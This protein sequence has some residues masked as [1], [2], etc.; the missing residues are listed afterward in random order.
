MTPN[1]PQKD[2]PNA[3]VEV[4]KDGRR[5]PDI[6]VASIGA[7]ILTSRSEIFSPYNNS[8]ARVVGFALFNPQNKALHLDRLWF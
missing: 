8:R 1:T 4:P 6:E 3:K 5:H 7:K 2:P